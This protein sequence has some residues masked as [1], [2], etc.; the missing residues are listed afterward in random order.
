MS[1]TK[2]IDEDEDKFSE[3]LPI[4]EILKNPKLLKVYY[5]FCEKERNSEAL[6]FYNEA[7]EYTKLTLSDERIKKAKKIYE[8]YIDE[9]APHSLNVNSSKRKEVK[10]KLQECPLD[11]FDGL[12]NEIEYLLLDPYR[13]F[14]HTNQYEEM[15]ALH[16][17]E[18]KLKKSEDKDDSELALLSPGI[19]LMA[20]SAS[21]KNDASFKT[22]T[23]ALAFLSERNIILEGPVVNKEGNFLEFKITNKGKLYF[24]DLFNNTYEFF[25]MAME[26]F[27]FSR[28]VSEK[29]PFTLHF[30]GGPTEYS[31]QKN[32]VYRKFID[33]LKKYKHQEIPPNFTSFHS[34][35]T[36]E[37]E[38]WDTL[39]VIEF[40]ST[41]YDKNCCFSIYEDSF[42]SISITGKELK[43]KTVEEYKQLKMTEEHAN[44]L[45]KEVENIVKYGYKDDRA[46]L[47]LKIDCFELSN[48]SIR[49]S[50]ILLDNELLLTLGNS[51][52]ILETYLN[53]N[54]H[55]ILHKD[56]EDY[57]TM[58]KTTPVKLILTQMIHNR[59]SIGF[60]ASFSGTI[61]KFST[62]DKPEKFENFIC[63]LIVGPFYLEFT[64]S[65]ICVPKR[66]NKAMSQ[67][68]ET[69]PEFS[70]I[71][72]PLTEVTSKLSKFISEWNTNYQFVEHDPNPKKQESN[73]YYFVE[74]ILK[75][76]KISTKF[77][78]SLVTFMTEM[79]EHGDSGAS[80]YPTEY[81]VE[82]E[83]KFGFSF[84]PKIEYHD[85]FDEKLNTIFEKEPDFRK[86][87]PHDFLV[88]QAIDLGFWIKHHQSPTHEEFLPLFEDMKSREKCLCPLFEDSLFESVEGSRSLKPTKRKE[89]KSFNLDQLDDVMQWVDVHVEDETE[90]VKDE[91]EIK[92]T[93]KSRRRSFTD[94]MAGL[95]SPTNSTGTKIKRRLSGIFSKPIDENA[96][97]AQQKINE[98]NKAK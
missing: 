51:N 11:I 3:A 37:I 5:D 16:E 83:K 91:E 29:K 66:I 1:N 35:M 90:A 79:K 94:S 38:K 75:L 81:V 60:E 24:L 21:K 70:T 26:K 96:M 4:K 76:F 80:I 78:G 92:E 63:A 69:I 34:R 85:E 56:L 7:K 12:N 2:V 40:L 6:D 95:F 25:D 19:A 39:N 77:R 43:R 62:G 44:K 64:K 18:N 74:E 8:E 13:R 49:S 15:L 48:P 46:K 10:N 71:K 42:D 58:S 31:F 14:F 97:T 98:I 33:I 57:D 45:K 87:Y 30:I 65:S 22:A 73:F 9:N 27:K 54:L 23:E 28:L 88:F 53:I 59:E 61:S 68:Y 41:I 82:F 50:N 84:I 17:I 52:D 93:K 86:K 55:S 20:I 72:K 36:K 67:I 32:Q 47:L 89:R